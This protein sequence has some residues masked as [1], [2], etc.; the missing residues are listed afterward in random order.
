MYGWKLPL[1]LFFILQVSRQCSLDT[2]YTS[3]LYLGHGVPVTKF[4]HHSIQMGVLHIYFSTGEVLTL[5]A[6][7]VRIG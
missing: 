2:A 5:S 7:T 4:S 1:I 6:T 3:N